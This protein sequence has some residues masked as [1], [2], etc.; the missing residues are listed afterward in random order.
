MNSTTS[1]KNPTAQ[2]LS[3]A[4]SPTA[5]SGT[6]KAPSGQPSPFSNQSPLRRTIYLL[7]TDHGFIADHSRRLVDDA[8]SFY[9]HRYQ[10]AL[11]YLSQEAASIRAKAIS[12][13]E[14]TVDVMA[15]ELSCPRDQYPYGWQ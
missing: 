2:S 3:T 12:G 15:L 14:P 9:T 7:A 1:T 5:T 8:S 13:V 11:T 10:D 6:Q 4:Q